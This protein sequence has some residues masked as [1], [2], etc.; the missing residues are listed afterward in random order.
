MEDKDAENIHERHLAEDR[1]S[2][3]R[4]HHEKHP[5]CIPDYPFGGA[6]CSASLPGASSAKT[7]RDDVIAKI[8]FR[9]TASAAP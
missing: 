5:Q 1:S 6:G 9:T 7:T 3:C 8:K 4:K 2:R